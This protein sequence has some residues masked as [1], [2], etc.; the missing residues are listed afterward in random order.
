M[1]C[2]TCRALIG[3][4]DWQPFNVSGMLSIA[5]TCPNG[6]HGQHNRVE[7]I[8]R[9]ISW[10]PDDFPPFAPVDRSEI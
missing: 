3:R 4:Y 6:H 7:T 10:A 8:I 5:W 9:P 2:T 1:I